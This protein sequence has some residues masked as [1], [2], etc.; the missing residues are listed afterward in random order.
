MRGGAHLRTGRQASKHRATQR[1]V[2]EKRKEAEQLAIRMFDNT[3]AIIEC[4]DEMEKEHEVDKGGEDFLNEVLRKHGEHGKTPSDLDTTLIHAPKPVVLELCIG[5]YREEYKDTDRGRR[6]M[7]FTSLLE[8]NNNIVDL[9]NELDEEYIS[10]MAG[11]LDTL[12]DPKGPTPETHGTKIKRSPVVSPVD[13]PVQ[14]AGAMSLSP[15]PLNYHD[16]G[17]KK[18]L[19]KMC[20]QCHYR[21]DSPHL[22]QDRHAELKGLIEGG[23]G[24]EADNIEIE[25]LDSARHAELERP[26]QDRHAELERP[27]QDRHAELLKLITGGRATDADNIEFERL[28]KVIHPG[29]YPSQ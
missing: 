22:D 7:E 21:L 15:M 26:D 20:N 18:V 2:D 16:D 8:G 11:H 10:H 1:M 13:E 14:I 17:G 24:T 19:H 3:N 29:L 28:D 12:N 9:A 25:R 6:C 23:R 4:I 27:D 5:K